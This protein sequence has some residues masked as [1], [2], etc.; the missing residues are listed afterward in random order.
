MVTFILHPDKHKPTVYQAIDGGFVAMCMECA[1]V[2]GRGEAEFI[3]DRLASLHMWQM[4]GWG[5]DASE[6]LGADHG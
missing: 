6:L 2:V 4:G 5:F 1:L 3:A